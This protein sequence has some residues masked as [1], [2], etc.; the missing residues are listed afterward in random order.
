MATQSSSKASRSSSRLGE[1]QND[2]LQERI[3]RWLKHPF[4][5]HRSS[6]PE[7]LWALK[8]VSLRVAEGEVLGLIGRNGAGKSTLLK[9][10]SK[11]TH[12]TAGRVSVTGRVAA[13]LE[14]EPASMAS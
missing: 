5:R 6:G 1:H 9:V 4:S 11:I 13:L 8:D 3:I 2:L 7:T 10:L 14:G 12:P